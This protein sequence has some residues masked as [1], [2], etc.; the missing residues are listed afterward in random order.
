MKSIERIDSVGSSQVADTLDILGLRSQVMDAAITPVQSGLRALGPAVTVAFEPSSS[1]DSD[2][3]YGD[4]IDV[5]DSLQPG[6]V[7]VIATS[8]FQESG[9]WGELFSAA[10]MGR[11]AVGVVTDGCSRDTPQVRDL[12]FAVFARGQKP[13]DYKARQV[14][15]STNETVVCGGVVV[16]QGDWVMADDDGVVVI[17]ARKADEALAMAV[18]RVRGESTVKDELLAGDTIRTVWERHGIL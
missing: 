15:V 4:M 2:D 16:S 18:E 8:S 1:V 5:I 13:L 17:P 7:V 11:G 6:A 12:G 9:L 14:V 10:A 3:P